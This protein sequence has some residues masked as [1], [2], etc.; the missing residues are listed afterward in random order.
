M[1]R[2]NRLAGFI[3]DELERRKIAALKRKTAAI[4]EKLKK[5]KEEKERKHL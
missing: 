3:L 1:S 5:D 4:M 2:Y